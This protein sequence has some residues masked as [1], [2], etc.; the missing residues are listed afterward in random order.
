MT[1]QYR[2]YAIGEDYWRTWG[3]DIVQFWDG[4]GWVRSMLPNRLAFLDDALGG[5][6]SVREVFD[7]NEIPIGEVSS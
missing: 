1:G 4:D 3:E 2:Y 6:G 7:L 5:G